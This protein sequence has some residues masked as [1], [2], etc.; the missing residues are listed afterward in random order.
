MGLLNKM[1][2]GIGVGGVGMG[3][4]MLYSPEFASKVMNY[5]YG[6]LPIPDGAIYG[7]D[8]KAIATTS[9]ALTSII[10]GLAILRD[11]WGD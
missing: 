5:L 7:I 6:Y 3:G 4:Y 11:L 2:L 1:K 9:V 8:Y 10:T